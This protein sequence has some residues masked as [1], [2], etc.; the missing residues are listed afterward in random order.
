MLQRMRRL[1]GHGRAFQHP[2]FRLH[3]A[4]RQALDGQ[5]VRLD[6]HVPFLAVCQFIG[7]V[8]AGGHRF[9]TR[10]RLVAV[11]R[12]R[13]GGKL[14]HL[15]NDSFGLV[16]ARRD[17][18]ARRL[19]VLPLQHRLH[20]TIDLLSGVAAGTHAHD[21]LEQTVEHLRHA[22][23]PVGKVR[24]LDGVDR[25]QAGLGRFHVHIDVDGEIAK[26]NRFLPVRLRQIGV[27]RS[28]GD[29]RGGRSR[30]LPVRIGRGGRLRLAEL[31]LV[32]PVPLVHHRLHLRR[33]L[34]G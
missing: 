25:E 4:A 18:S 15:G 20:D 11:R 24:A 33:R 16:I 32:H 26:S 34:A 3:G 13:G 29:R 9:D 7:P 21:V 12:G 8:R 22:R 6:P 1:P 19:V 31:L 27:W 28:G 5:C 23:V 10:G 14:R 17:E 2:A 30:R